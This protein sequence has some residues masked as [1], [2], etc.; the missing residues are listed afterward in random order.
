MIRALGQRF[1][2]F[3]RATTPDP[4]VLAVL[5]TVV[6][7]GGAFALTNSSPAE[8]IRAWQGDAG[9]WS[10]LAFGMQMVLILVTG[11]ALASAPP[12]SRL[13]QTLASRPVSAPG[14]AAMVSFVAMA[15]G[16]LNW[17]LGLIVGAILA[18][19]TGRSLAARGI[20]CHY[21][22]LAAAGYTG[23][24]CWH[25]GLSGTAPLMVTSE[26]NLRGFLGPELAART[27]PVPFTETVLSPANLLVS[28]GLLLL[29]PALAAA[30]CPRAGDPV[31]GID[32]FA[33]GPPFVP[34][35]PS[36]ATIPE[37]LE[38]SPWV[39]AL[40]VIPLLAAV[41]LWMSDVG[42][43]QLDPN[44]LNLLFLALGI[45]L[46]GSLR[47]YGAAVHDAVSGASGIVLQ[48]PFYAGIMGVMRVTGLA[49]MFSSSIVNA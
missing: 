44:A 34:T 38:A 10:L 23:L 30:L 18:R 25:G 12:V 39:A 35:A 42:I 14:A 24:L 3:F 4:L 36:R 6:A 8:V 26:E 19:D 31:E 21:P 28:L 47:Q 29:I 33:P 48:F 41:G 16:L 1:A 45:G 49:A 32:A 2:A 22:I 9:F 37:R 20:P 40:I 15:T 7:L 5:L 11:H 13:L 46:H 43:T 17:G 27:G